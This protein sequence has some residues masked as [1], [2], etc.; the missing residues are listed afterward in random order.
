MSK[1]NIVV[2][3][4][5]TTEYELVLNRETLIALANPGPLDALSKFSIKVITLNDPHDD[6]KELGKDTAVVIAWKTVQQIPESTEEPEDP[7]RFG[8]I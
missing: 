6:G 3:S 8:S 7:R 1:P 2:K 5:H 4:K